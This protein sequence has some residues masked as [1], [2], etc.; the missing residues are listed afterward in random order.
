MP[1]WKEQKISVF[2]LSILLASEKAALVNLTSPARLQLIRVCHR[3]PVFSG[4]ICHYCLDQD[5]IFFPPI[6]NFVSFKQLSWAGPI[7]ATGSLCAPKC[8]HLFW[9]HSCAKRLC[10]NRHSLWTHLP[11]PLQQKAREKNSHSLQTS[12]RDA[13]FPSNCLH[14]LF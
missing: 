1:G 14:Y 6:A 9:A 10:W 5:S 3:L 12:H 8:S 4:S 2:R 11:F 7:L 13:D